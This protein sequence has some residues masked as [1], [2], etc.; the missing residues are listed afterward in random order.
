MKFSICGFSFHRDFF[1]GECFAATYV[2]R[3][4]DLGAT[5]LHWWLPQLL[6][7]ISMDELKAWSWE[8]GPAEIPSWMHAPQDQ[9]WI[10]E[11]NTIIQASGL[12]NEAL[13]MEKGYLVLDDKAEQAKHRQ[14]LIEW[15]ECAGKLGIPSLRVDP[16]PLRN[17]SPALIDASIEAYKEVSAIGNDHGVRLFIENHWGISQDPCYVN[18]V[19]DEVDNIGYLFDSWNWQND[20]RLAA[21]DQCLERAETCHIKTFQLGDDGID[22]KYPVHDAIQR[23]AKQDPDR[24]WGIESVPEDGDE[25]AGARRCMDLIR[26][27][28][29]SVTV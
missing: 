23:L 12:E 10:D 9:G 24:V 21:W 7:N 26:R 14:F 27:E 5:H 29:S 4:K 28:A 22:A 15:I 1:K 3:C 8:P 16:G 25:V 13:A 17:A 11:L 19:L 20:E 2:Q 6:P 18:R